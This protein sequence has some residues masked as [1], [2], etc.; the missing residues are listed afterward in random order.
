MVLI[1]ILLFAFLTY[2]CLFA[3]E[4]YA[5]RPWDKIHPRIAGKL[6]E[7]PLQKPL[8]EPKTIEHKKG[9]LIS[10]A[11]F[12][13]TARVLAVKSYWIGRESEI[14]PFDIVIGWKDY[15][16]PQTA[17]RIEFVQY[18]RQYIFPGSDK[19]SLPN[20]IARHTANIHVIPANKEVLE[21]LKTIKVGKITRIRGQLVNFSGKAANAFFWEEHRKTWGWKT[22]LTRN[23]R[24]HRASE[25][26]YLEDVEFF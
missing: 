16:Q 21:K 2:V 13:T 11:N 23:D 9:R 20:E 18:G 14:A 12:E 25:I 3:A 17:K 24:G 7:E 22:S 6:Q 26:L 19:K 8:E 5:D 10:M 1:R 4:H 15:A